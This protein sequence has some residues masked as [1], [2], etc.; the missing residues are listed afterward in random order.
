M[1]QKPVMYVS[2]EEYKALMRASEKLWW[3]AFISLAYG[4]GLRC[5]EILNLTW[6]DID[7]ANQLIRI[8]TKKAGVGILEWEPKDHENRVGGFD[9]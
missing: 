4:S 8:T 9:V 6:A 3:K 7:F 1:A 2:V 5:G